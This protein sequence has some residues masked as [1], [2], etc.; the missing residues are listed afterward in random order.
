ME[1]SCGLPLSMPS[2]A[3]A[4]KIWRNSWKIQDLKKKRFATEMLYMRMRFV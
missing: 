1:F 3:F 4:A 2:M